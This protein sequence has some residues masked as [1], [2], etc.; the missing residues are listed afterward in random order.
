MLAFP[1]ALFP[2]AFDGLVNRVE[3]FLVTKRLCQEFDR[4]RLHRP[5]RHRHVSVSAD[6]YD[7]DSNLLLDKAMLQIETAYAGKPDIEYQAARSIRTFAGQ[8]FLSRRKRFD[9]EPNRT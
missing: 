5:Y 1:P 2:I 3:K 6:K 4:A 8:E 9:L 7:R